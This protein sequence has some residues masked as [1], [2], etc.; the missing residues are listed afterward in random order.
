MQLETAESL[1]AQ[2]YLGNPVKKNSRA[3]ASLPQ[4]HRLA[5]AIFLAFGMASAVGFAPLSAFAQEAPASPP[6]DE[7]L[8]SVTVTARKVSEQQLDVPISIQAFSE[9]EL[10]ESGTFDL[11]DLKSRAG[12]NFTTYTAGAAGR[13]NGVIVFRGLQGATGLVNENSGSLFIDG[14]FISSGQATVNTLDALRVEVLKGPQNTYFGRSTFGGAINFI[15]RTPAMDALHAEINSSFTDR[16]SNDI[17]VS[18]E[19]PLVP[20]VLSARLLAYNHDKAAT[21]KSTDGGDLGAEKSRGVTGT[22][23]FTPT[24]NLWIRARGNYQKDDDGPAAYGYIAA[25]GNTSCN[26]VGFSAGNFNGQP[27]NYRTGVNYFCGS[28]PTHGQTGDSVIDSQTNLPGPIYNQLT[29]NGP[30]GNEQF[31]PNG[32]IAKDP[33]L[34]K[35]PLLTHMGMAREAIHASTQAGLTLPLDMELDFNAGYNQ[36]NQ[37]SAYDSLDASAKVNNF[38]NIQTILAHD[39]TLDVRLQSSRNQ[40]IRGMIGA[41]YFEQT[42]QLSQDD[43]NTAYFSNVVQFNP[44]NYANNKSKVPAAYLAGEW[45][46]VR[47]LTL[48][49]EARYQQDHISTVTPFAD[50][51]Y[52]NKKENWLPRGSL[53][54]KPNEDTTLYISAAKGVEPLIANTLLASLSPAQL[55]YVTSFGGTGVFSPQPKVAT[56]EVGIKQRLLDDRIQY[57]FAYYDSRWDNRLTYTTLFNP[58]SC[59]ATTNTVACPL[60]PAGAGIYFANNA[61]IKGVEFGLDALIMKNWTAGGEVDY[62][63]ARWANFFYSALSSATGVGVLNGNAYY[64]DGKELGKQPKWT[65][66]V[67]STYK[68][69]GVYQ[70]FDGYVRGDVLYTGKSWESDMNYARVNGYTKVNLRAGVANKGVTVELF[71]KNLF[72]NKDWL[73]AYR[74]ANLQLQP[75]TSFSQQG[76]YVQPGD[77]REVGVRLAYRF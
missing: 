69:P 26:G 12:F 22:L 58:A 62:T 39:T 8:E 41:S 33:F 38:T 42:Y 55:S 56:Y 13:S 34:S 4:R 24:D 28:I 10:R 35:G 50:A 48:S 1:S 18:M 73:Y 65:A 70:N 63:N 52:D 37:V 67:N 46:I 31:P 45:D 66:S 75:L 71:A 7:K 21:Y 43:L 25:N 54:F 3:I 27:I 11:Y 40:P 36:S 60:S 16:G 77:P 61:R 17:D 49:L 32:V 47:N 2:D 5:Q 6:P 74:G 9:K 72:N 19:G 44:Y 20:N 29:N 68:V 30:I 51:R 64:F 59:G 14:I 15:T 23:Y 76:V 53:R 57:S